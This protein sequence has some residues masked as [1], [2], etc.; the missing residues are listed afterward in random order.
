LGHKSLRELLA[1]TM[2]PI[3]FCGTTA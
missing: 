3:G 1:L 2:A